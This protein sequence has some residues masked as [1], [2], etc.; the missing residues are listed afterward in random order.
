MAGLVR[1][2]EAASLALHAMGILA[3]N[4]DRRMSN[5]ELATALSASTHHLAKVMQRLA[6]AG[7]VKST[8]GPRGGFQ[9]S[10]R[11]HEIRLAEIYE[12]VDGPLPERGCLLTDQIC[13]GGE[14]M[15]G[16]L[17]GAIHQ[18]VVSYLEHT[19]LAQM[20]NGLHIV[21]A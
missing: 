8:R 10:R 16:D 3:R 20:A 4:P 21:G 19:T 6:R 5:D 9:I 11:P 13:S 12:A 2:S 15:L 1:F 7:L 18:Q 17:M 14:C